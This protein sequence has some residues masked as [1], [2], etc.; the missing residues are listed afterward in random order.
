M[1]RKSRFLLLDIKDSW[2]CL[3]RRPLRSFLSSLGIGIG[4]A[5]LI[6]MLS[7]SEGARLSALRK[8]ESLG[9]NTLRI[10]QKDANSPGIEK[11]ANLSRGLNLEDRDLLSTWAGGRGL[12]SCYGRIVNSSVHYSTQSTSVTI[13]GVNPLWFKIEEMRVS[14]GRLLLKDD[15]KQQARYCVLGSKVANALEAPLLSTIQTRGQVL[16]VVGIAQPKGR[17]MT[18]GT[19]LSSLDFDR[20]IYIP[21]STLNH[22]MLSN[23]GSLVDGIVFKRFDDGQEAI[24]S[25]AKQ[26]EQIIL[27]SHGGVKDFSIVVP[28]ALLEEAHESQR[29]FSLIMGVIAGLSLL[30]GG[31]GVLNVMLANIAEQTRDIGLRM[32]IGAPPWR[33]L[34]FYLCHSALLSLSGSI[35]GIG[36]GI[37]LAVAVQHYADWNIAFSYISILI[38][39]SAAIITGVIFGLHPAIRA[40]SLEPA[41]ALRDS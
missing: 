34:W 39:P 9:V 33:I 16:K 2:N 30:V 28:Y 7:I 5:A 41:N 18:E 35:W 4:V 13:L 31:I 10:E 17:L 14:A 29:T 8:I 38:A 37:A 40:A 26:V 24:T 20:A 6:A 32:A 27:E 3:R 12:V 19:G 21:V 15:E 36:A 22:S 25:I 11:F 23:R 1:T